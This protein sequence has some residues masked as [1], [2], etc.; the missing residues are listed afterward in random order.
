MDKNFAWAWAIKNSISV[1]CW[2]VLAVV[3]NKWWIAL[4]AVLFIGGYARV[5][6]YYRICDKCGK[7]S[8][9]EDSYDNAIKRAEAVGWIHYDDGNRDY[10]PD[11]QLKIYRQNLDRSV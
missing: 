1:I 5:H 10:C 2:V 6:K 11:C 8:P 3:F 9:Y 7:H 4:F